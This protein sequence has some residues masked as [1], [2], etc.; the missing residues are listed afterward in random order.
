MRLLHRDA[1]GTYHLK[2]IADALEERY[3][4]LS[5]RWYPDG[6]ILYADLANQHQPQIRNKQGWRKLQYAVDQ[7]ERDGYR[8]VWIDTCCIDKTSSAELSEAINSMFF[9]YQQAQ[10]CYAYLWDISGECPPLSDDA[11]LG[12]E[13]N[14]NVTQDEDQD[15]QKSG[16]DPESDGL[17]QWRVTFAECSWFTRGW[18]LQELIA[19]REVLFFGVDW[20]P[21][22]SSHHL[23]ETIATKTLIDADLLRGRKSLERYSIAQRMS[24]AADRVTSRIEDRAYS[25][26]GLFDVNIPLL[27][28]EREKAFMRL[29]EEIIRRSPDESIFAWGCDMSVDETP[30]RLL[31]RSPTDFRGSS[32]IVYLGVFGRAKALQLDNQALRGIFQVR[33]EGDGLWTAMLNCKDSKGGSIKLSVVPQDS[34]NYE[35]RQSRP[36]SPERLE[37]YDPRRLSPLTHNRGI[38]AVAKSGH[39]FCSRISSSRAFPVPASRP[40]DAWGAPNAKEDDVEAMLLAYSD[41]K[42]RIVTS[43]TAYCGPLRLSVCPFKEQDRGSLEISGAAP[44]GRILATADLAQDPLLRPI[45]TRFTYNDT[46]ALLI[47]IKHLNEALEVTC[48][49]KRAS[50]VHDKNHFVCKGSLV[51]KRY[52][53]KRENYSWSL[54][55]W[56]DCETHRRHEFQGHAALCT[57]T[58]KDGWKFSARMT[59][60][61]ITEPEVELEFKTLPPPRKMG[62]L[63]RLVDREDGKVQFESA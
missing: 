59:V 44:W 62:G 21:L 46:A 15:G 32:G 3:T 30:G 57:L 27:Y 14:G 63:K 39:G 51:V 45:V 1:Q 61:G 16:V 55:A 48:T 26:L 29:Q 17:Q 37:F 10:V 7:A 47:R 24:W 41:T 42:L 35:E 33:Y 34:F 54:Q 13:G 36:E 53:R 25:L 50:W 4:I 5:H 58:L 12:K 28:G 31:A 56:R 38:V 20:N 11:V 60:V 19:P 49:A 8:Y 52:T 23:V 43:G 6:D 40:V 9:W 18:T 2:E 22:G